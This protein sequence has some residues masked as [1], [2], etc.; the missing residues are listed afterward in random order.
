MPTPRGYFASSVVDNMIYAI[1]GY[2][3]H[4]L[5]WTLGIQKC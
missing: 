5:N 1:G 2:D 3:A 4:N